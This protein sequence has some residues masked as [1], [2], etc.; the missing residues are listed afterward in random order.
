MSIDA[1]EQLWAPGKKDKLESILVFY[2]EEE[3]YYP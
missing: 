3:A 1:R 2:P